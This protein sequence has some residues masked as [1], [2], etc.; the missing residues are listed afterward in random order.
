MLIPSLSMTI[1]YLSSELPTSGIL[2]SCRE[3]P[4]GVGKMMVTPAMR[5]DRFIHALGEIGIR[6]WLVHI[7]KVGDPVIT[8]VE[9]FAPPAT[10]VISATHFVPRHTGNP[11]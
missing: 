11:S 10:S 6:R 4:T 1:N 2:V 3:D 7:Q 9:K 5:H 8:R